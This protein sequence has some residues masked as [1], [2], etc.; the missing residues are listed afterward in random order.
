[1]GRKKVKDLPLFHELMK[2]LIK[3]LIALVV[4]VQLKN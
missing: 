4:Q 2:P 1:M 3:A